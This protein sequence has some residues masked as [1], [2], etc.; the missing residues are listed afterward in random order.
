MNTKLWFALMII[1]FVIIIVLTWLLFALPGKRETV[2]TTTPSTSESTSTV[3]N[4][5]EEKPATT[6]AK[7][8]TVSSPVSGAT[9]AKT[10]TVAGEAPGTWYFEAVFPIE[11]RNASGTVI[12]QSH[13]QAQ[14]D[15]MTTGM[16]PFTSS[17]SVAQYSGPAT[18]VLKNDNPSGDPARDLT[19]T[20][21]IV[22]Q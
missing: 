9:V 16:V 21:P 15:W 18:I 10:F 17:I 2:A 1:L 7:K 22:I 11:V 4:P 12:A 6:T 3:P 5:G 19:M 20:I 13:A 8:P 14:G